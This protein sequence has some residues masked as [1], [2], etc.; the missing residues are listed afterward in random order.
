MKHMC[1]SVLYSTANVKL[2]YWTSEPGFDNLLISILCREPDWQL[3]SI[4]QFC[5]SSLHPV[6]TVEDLYIERQYWELV[7]M[8]DAIGEH[9]MASTLTSIYRGE[10]Y[11]RIKG[12]C[13]RYRSR[14]A[15]AH[16]CQNNRRVAQPA[17]YFCGGARL[18]VIE[19]F[20][21]KLWTVRRCA[22][23]LQSP[24]RHFYL[25]Q[26]VQIKA[27]VMQLVSYGPYSLAFT[28]I[29]NH[30]S[31]G[32]AQEKLAAAQFASPRFLLISSSGS[33]L[34][35]A[36]RNRTIRNGRALHTHISTFPS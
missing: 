4:E 9:P 32:A 22:T 21:E 15:R 5:N 26:I 27:M 23:A 24:C 1:N 10:E 35:I 17:E 3:S 28:S 19:T 2:R 36:K 11:L 13:A 34:G 29:L 16:W 7:P 14:P 20:P 18:G 25:E 31:R 6:S 12:I 33:C 8:N 30:S